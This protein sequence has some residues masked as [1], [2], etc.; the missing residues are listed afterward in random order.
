MKRR[1][2]SSSEARARRAC[3]CLGAAA[4]VVA[5]VLWVVAGAAAKP[6]EK[7]FKIVPGSFHVTPS[8]Y[9][10]GAHEDLTVTFNFETTAG[11]TN[12]DLKSSVVE[13]PPGF[14][15]SNTAVP[16]CSA[17]QLLA[18]AEPDGEGT[19]C[20]PASQV[21][22]IS[23]DLT[24]GPEPTRETF[25]LY[26]MEV[27]SFG[28]AA[29]LG[30]RT[31]LLSQLLSVNVRP[32]DSGLTITSPNVVEIAEAH[33]VSVTTWG[34]PA[35]H[36]HDPQRGQICGNF[37][38]H[39]ECLGGG[40][41]ADVAPRPFL[42][43]P[44]ACESSVA[45]MRADSWE[46][47]DSWTTEETAVEPIVECESVH[48]EPAIEA[49]PTVGAA[50]SPTGLDFAIGLPQ[51]WE[52]PETISTA[53]LKD[54][55]VTLPE[56]MSLNPSEGAGLGYCTEAQFEEEASEYVP[57][58]GCPSESKVGTVEVETPVLAEKAKSTDSAV[59]VAKPFDNPFHSLLALYIV[60]RI[61]SRGIVV[62][63][64]GEVHPDPVTGRLTTTFPKNP[65]VPFS[66]FS[67]HFDQGATSP[68][69][70]PAACGAFTVSGELTP[71]SAPLEPTSL[72]A[73]PFAITSGVHGGLCPSG[74]L[75]PFHPL[76]HA[77]SYSNQAGAYTPFYIR[78]SREDGEQEITHFSIK[79]P[80]GLVGKLAGI[81]LCSD[82]A[83]AA[84]KARTGQHGGQEEEES[85][86][87]PAASQI[88]RTEVEAGVGSVL[89]SAP[90]KIYLAGP[91]HGAPISVAAITS[92]K[93]GPFDLGT[94]VV[95]E[96]LK[97]NPETAEVFVDATGS[98]PLP[99]IIQ[100]IP[101]HLRNIRIYMDRP[102]FVLNPTNCSQT[103]TA[104]TVLG[105][106]KDFASEADDQPV[107]VSSPFQVANCA[108][109]A[110]KPALAL[111]L[112]GKTRRGGLPKLVATVTY[113]EGGSYANIAR[114]VVSLPDSELLEQ[115]HIGTS[116]TRVQFNAGG[117]NGEQ[118]PP[119]SIYGHAR[120]LTPLLE[121]PV[122]GPVYLRSN[123]GE[124]QLPDLVAALHS[125]DININLLGF[126]DSV[127]KKGSEKS[128]IRTR[129]LSVPD[130]PVSKFTLEMFGGKKGLLINSTNLCKGS[131]RAR[132]RFTGQNGKLYETEP[133]VQARC[134]RP[135]AKKNVSGTAKKKGGSGKKKGGH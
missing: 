22:T 125:K 79:L 18:T 90:G 52:S 27:S 40:E 127:H 75:P 94:V 118:C 84:A 9:R 29:Q 66:K 78:L 55:T 71:W 132:A 104:S 1:S 45:R 7:P 57:G 87:C 14:I 97:V 101:T 122:E 114:A 31:A 115:G 67:L 112:L 17:A 128:S 38:S 3:R 4:V 131:H 126:I 96:G 47:P 63:V 42:S 111:K 5:G 70:T 10:A 37:G 80:P 64:A 123:G 49:Q 58:Q 91:Y 105:S 86:S 110:F 130:A 77:G 93:V 76:L 103:S 106:G 24:A 82:A 85:P 13:L 25:P 46:D 119:T 135:G 124:R 8:T 36:L 102:E 98:D 28:I 88:G 109:L 20:P 120:A 108:A 99:H 73:P 129:F 33:D 12:N 2:C 41:E 44:T 56:G 81:P 121:E 69:V 19:L 61:P 74:G 15:G 72:S 62:K 134:G 11:K 50:E 43:N 53:D 60:A 107:T 54:A 100:G 26:N 6:S 21:G 89:A 95:R 65:Q 30:F 51:T 39:F 116:C 48:F 133:K 16:T 23:L 68:L 35:L 32:G 92:A 59:Y 113:P 117:G 34:V 83:I